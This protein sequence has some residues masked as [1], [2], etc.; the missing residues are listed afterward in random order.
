MAAFFFQQPL[1]AVQTAIPA[2]IY[3][4]PPQ[5]T[6]TTLTLLPTAVAA[7]LSTTYIQHPLFLSTP[8]APTFTVTAPAATANYYAGGM[9]MVLA[10][11]P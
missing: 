1:F 6:C 5:P 3:R 11:L 9:P 10:R 4:R 2:H 8:H 7:P